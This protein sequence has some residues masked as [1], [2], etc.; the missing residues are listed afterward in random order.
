MNNDSM[1]APALRAATTRMFQEA[2]EAPQR[3]RAQ[4]EQDAALVS[5]VADALRR[6]NP[7]AVLT[8]ARGSS[9]HAATYRALSDRNPIWGF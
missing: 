5:R 1:T 2:K 9:D 7:R 6:F 8:C 4:L 3:V